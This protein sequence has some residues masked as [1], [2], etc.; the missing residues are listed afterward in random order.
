M[1]NRFTIVL[2]TYDLL[3]SAVHGNLTIDCSLAAQ[4]LSDNVDHLSYSCNSAR[5]NHS[6]VQ[7]RN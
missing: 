2:A 4:V 3:P 5:R 7:D 6:R 1:R